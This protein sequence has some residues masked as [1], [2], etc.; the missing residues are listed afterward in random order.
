MNLYLSQ[1]SPLHSTFSTEEGQ[2]LYKVETPTFELTGRTATISRVIP[3]NIGEHVNPDMRDR[4]ALMAQ[5]DFV[6]FG[7]SKLKFDGNEYTTK[8]YFRKVGLGFHGRWVYVRIL[9][10]A[11]LKHREKG[12]VYSLGQMARSTDGYFIFMNQRY[13]Y[14][15]LKR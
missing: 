9:L 15:L 2:V 3:N 5:I 14:L 11:S 7:V 13:V 1:R 10:H 6:R 12:I 4:F 8:K